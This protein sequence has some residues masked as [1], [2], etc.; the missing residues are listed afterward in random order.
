MSS[1]KPVSERAVVF[2]IGAVQFVNILDFV[3]VMPLGPDFARGLGIASSHIGTIGGSYT[4]AASVMGLA[5][6]YFLDF[7]LK[8]DE[9][10]R[11]G[12]S[13]DDANMMV[14]TAVGGDNQSTTVEGR[15]RYGINV[16]YA[17]D[18][19]E[20]LQS[21]KRV[22]LPLPNGQGQIPM[23]AIADVVLA[24]GPSMIRN[25]NGLLTRVWDTIHFAPPF[26]ITTDE[27]DRM[28]TIVDD[29]LTAAGLELPGAYRAL[30]EA[31]A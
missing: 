31:A 11:Y 8:R 1:S 4:L 17:R 16:R 20:D 24:H 2:L 29:A 12:L 23:E 30:V 13:V 7:V 28:V 26:V 3:M 10:A 21:L 5:G 22:L 14:M 18:Y 25:E 19:R 27:I 9:L 6:G 15:E